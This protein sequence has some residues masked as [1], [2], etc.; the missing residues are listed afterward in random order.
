MRASPVTA[1]SR[2]RGAASSPLVWVLVPVVPTD[3]PNLAWYS[4]HSMAH[5]EFAR[6]FEALKA[7]WRW[8][9]ISMKDHKQV[10][11]RM[12]KES[13]GRDTT[14]LNLCD[15]EEINGSP[16]LSII[17]ALRTHGLRFTGSDERFY[18]LTTSKIVMKRLFDDAQVP[19]APWAVVPRD[20]V[21][22][23]PLFRSI[24]APLI[25]KPAIS[26]GSLGIG[27]K[28]VVHSHQALRAQLARLHD[29]YRGWSLADGGAFVERFIDGP[30]FTT[31]IVGSAE[32][33]RRATI[34]PPVERFFNPTIPRTERFLS[35]D[36]L[37]G[38]YEEESEIDGGDGELWRYRPARA[39][40]I[41]RINEVSWQA[42]KAVH[43][44][45]YGRVDLRRDRKTGEFQVLEV[46]AQCGLSE[47]E[48]YT[49]IGAILRFAKIPYHRAVRAILQAANTP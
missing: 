31:F 6:A 1:S 8:Q 42:Y 47:D 32:D 25:L 10:I 9:P 5:A 36:R 17:R 16:G 29:G 4:D 34:Y 30:E 27:L 20:G 44:R 21:G 14:V 49:S 24:G 19:T 22:C 40:L 41:E 45:G 13:A 12:A 11:A 33:R 18:D 26:A 3:D 2:A 38:L 15:G 7:E 28:S 39:D 35:F 46:N 43:G 23:A 37:W 48:L